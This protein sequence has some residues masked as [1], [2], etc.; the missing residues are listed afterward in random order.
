MF[1]LTCIVLAFSASPIFAQNQYTD[2]F[3]QTLHD[4][5]VAVQHA[6]ELALQ[7]RIF[8][9]QKRHNLVEEAIQRGEL[10]D[11]YREAHSG[12][13]LWRTN[14][15]IKE[16]FAACRQAHNDCNK[17]GWVMKIVSES[18]P[19]DWNRITA[20]EYVECLDA[21]AKTATFAEEA[22]QVALKPALAETTRQ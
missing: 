4:G 9:E 5:T 11:G 17:L 16:A 1:R 2:P 6:Q 7:Q 15:D 13:A 3:F 8:D 10:H 12:Q 22:R 14:Q 19:P 20:K 21:V 18:L